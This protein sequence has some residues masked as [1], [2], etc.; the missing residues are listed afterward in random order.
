MI[1]GDSL[2]RDALAEFLDDFYLDTDVASRA[3]RLTERPD[4][5][6]DM[7]REAY[8]AAIAEHL[9][10]RWMLGDAPDWVH[11]QHRFLSRPFFLGAERDKPFLLAESPAAFRRRFIFT[12]A[13]PLRRARMPQDLKWWSYENMR[14][15]SIPTMED[16]LHAISL[17]GVKESKIPEILAT[18][19][20]GE[21]RELIFN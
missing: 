8:L 20:V 11:E 2:F 13:E 15:G 3:S 7:V 6:D 1:A 21:R 16:L 18:W 14:N 17:S 4:S 5:C 10:A 12:E 9:S 19:Q